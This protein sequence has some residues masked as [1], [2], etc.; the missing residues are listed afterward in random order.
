VRFFLDNCISPILA[1]AL[2]V[3]AE[4][5]QYDIIHLRDRFEPETRDLDWIPVLAAEGDW[6]IISGDT[7]ISRSKAE[8]AAWHESG[9]TA[10]FL[11]DDWSQKKFWTQAAELV[12]WWPVIVL[13]ARQAPS[14]SG[15]VCLRRVGSSG[16]STHLDYFG[17][18][19]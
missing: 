11:S 9:L 15:F 4:F 16:G 19:R 12:R 6:V 8:R 10:F 5:Q 18:G 7:R 2:A 13:T 14:G 3:L 17:R 1:R